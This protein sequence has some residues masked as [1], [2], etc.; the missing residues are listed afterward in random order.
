MNKIIIKFYLNFNLINILF[1]NI[2]DNILQI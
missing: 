2:L 1:N